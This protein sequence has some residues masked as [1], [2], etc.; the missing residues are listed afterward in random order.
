M[1]DLIERHRKAVIGPDGR[2]DAEELYHQLVA[3]NDGLDL[4]AETDDAF[5]ALAESAAKNYNASVCDDCGRHAGRLIRGICREC[6]SRPT[7]AEREDLTHELDE[8]DRDIA[9]LTA[10]RNHIRRQLD[11]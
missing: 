8:I 3:E 2:V 6:L 1:T 9:E 7:E 5:V 10:R 4:D 11:S